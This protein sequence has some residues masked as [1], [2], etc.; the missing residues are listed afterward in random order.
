MNC[1]DGNFSWMVTNVSFGTR[2]LSSIQIQEVFPGLVFMQWGSD[3]AIS[4]A[5]VI[6]L[7]GTIWLHSV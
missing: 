7:F 3:Q 2:N 5:K 6:S 1:C 4:L